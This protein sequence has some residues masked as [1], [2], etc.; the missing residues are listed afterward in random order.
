M[1]PLAY[2]IAT[3]ASE[4][5]AI[6]R[7]NYDTFVEEIP[8]HAANAERRLVDRFHAQNTYVICLDGPR[9]AG[10]VCGRCVRPFSLDQKV[11]NLDRYLPAHRKAVEIRLL[12]IAPA[13]RKTTVFAGLIGF[14]Y[15]A[16]QITLY[17]AE[18]NVVRARRLYPRSILQPPLTPADERV[19]SDIAKEGERRP[20]QRVAVEFDRSPAGGAGATSDSGAAS[21]PSTGVRPS[22]DDQ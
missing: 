7:L 8:Q 3:E 11:A 4:F 12:A 15:L 16:C 14:L 13:Y 20:E 9:M 2:K 17:A 6:H 10:M 1:V 22:G 18:L 19:L 21:S 5:E